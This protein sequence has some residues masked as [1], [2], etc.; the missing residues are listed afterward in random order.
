MKRELTLSQVIAIGVVAWL[1]VVVANMKPQQQRYR[2][3][4]E[5]NDT[6]ECYDTQ[7]S[8]QG[9]AIVKNGRIIRVATEH[10]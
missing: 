1:I 9:L 8:W 4:S 10:K 7:S 3:I 5:R 2:V 6:I